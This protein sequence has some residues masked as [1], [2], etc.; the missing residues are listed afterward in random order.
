MLWCDKTLPDSPLPNS[1][2][3]LSQDYAQK[4]Q[5]ADEPDYEHLRASFRRLAER[6]GIALDAKWDWDGF[7]FCQ[8]RGLVA[9]KDP[10]PS[11]LKG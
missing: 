2:Q 11:A 5:F 10:R 9:H 7:S 1:P 8:D 6:K 3:R 4:L